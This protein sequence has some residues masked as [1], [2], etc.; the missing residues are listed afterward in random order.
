M[1]RDDRFDPARLFGCEVL[2]GSGRTLGRVTALVH[3][4]DGCDVLVERRQWLRHTVVRVDI[5]DL[6]EWDGRSYRLVPSKRR[7]TGPG[8]GRVA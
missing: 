2:D 1:A 7:A 4:G 8:D 3:R 6:A 5:D